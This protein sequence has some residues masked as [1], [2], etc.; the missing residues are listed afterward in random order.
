MI[1]LFFVR[2][3][4]QHIDCGSLGDTQLH[5]QTTPS[6]LNFTFLDY[7]SS[8]SYFLSVWSRF[9]IIG[10]SA[11]SVNI[12]QLILIGSFQLDQSV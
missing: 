2:S 6:V 12:L 5:V 10:S 4:R 1:Y 7:H 3:E 9:P 11:V 8:E